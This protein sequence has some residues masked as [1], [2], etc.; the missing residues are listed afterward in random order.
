[1]NCWI[2]SSTTLHPTPG[3]SA[4]TIV[5]NP[6]P[7]YR[8]LR[9]SCATPSTQRNHLSLRNRSNEENIQEKTQE[10]RRTC[11]EDLLHY[12]HEIITSSRAVPL[13]FFIAFTAAQE[14]RKETSGSTLSAIRELHF[15]VTIKPVLE[16][17]RSIRACDE[18][19]ANTRR[20]SGSSRGTS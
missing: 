16:N 2:Q 4:W 3:N 17:S 10:K 18:G 6:S 7:S 9:S 1:M 11:T 20:T 8:H 19:I 14:L 12:T 13:Y 5:P 15:F